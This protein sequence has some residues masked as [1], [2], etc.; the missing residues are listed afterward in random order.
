MRFPEDV[1]LEARERAKRQ[2]LDQKRVQA[3]KDYYQDLRKQYVKVDEE[4][5]TSL[6]YESKEPGFEKLLKDK[7]VIAEIS[8]EKPITVGELTKALKQKFYHGVE[9]AITSASI[10][11]RKRA[12]L[13]EILRDRV[14]LKEAFKQNIDKMEI[15]KNRIKEYEKALI[16]GTFIEKV[17]I[18]DNW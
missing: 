15:Y 1:D 3:A 7:R 2:V 5:F 12:V 13:E 16:F 11:K 10:N 8:G 6:D 18:P 4:I 9:R 17:I 14:W